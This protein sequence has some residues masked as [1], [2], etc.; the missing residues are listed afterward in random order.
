MIDEDRELGQ[1]VTRDFFLRRFLIIVPVFF[2]I[3]LLGP[4]VRSTHSSALHVVYV[5]VLLVY[6]VG[7]IVIFMRRGRRDRQWLGSGDRQGR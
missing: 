6:V 1:R 2:Y 3:L 4:L 7:V 5:A